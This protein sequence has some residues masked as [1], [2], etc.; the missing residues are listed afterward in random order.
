MKTL[1]DEFEELNRSWLR[2]VEELN[3]L[4][5][6]EIRKGNNSNHRQLRDR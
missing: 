2:F 4:V 3:K 6:H 1:H 5:K